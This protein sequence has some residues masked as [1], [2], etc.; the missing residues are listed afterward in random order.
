MKKIKKLKITESHTL[1]L[2]H[3]QDHSVSKG[4]KRRFMAIKDSIYRLAKEK[5]ILFGKKLTVCDIGCNA[6]S[7]SCL[8]LADGHQIFGIDLD[9]QLLKLAK[10]SFEETNICMGSAMCLPWKSNSFDVCLVPELLEHVNEWEKCLDEFARIL[11]PAGLL[12]ISTVNTLCPKQQE[13]NLPFYSWYPKRLKK[14]CEKLA[15]GPRPDLANYATFPAVSWFSF[16]SLRKELKNRGFCSYGRF[17]IVDTSNK[18]ELFKIILSVLRKD[19]FMKL[20][21]NILTPYTVIL[22]IKKKK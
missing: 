1:F 17:D 2:E 4:T 14:Y 6:G 20:I 18:S 22:G 10:K 9:W 12:Y 16:Y 15:T 13:F 19:S 21:G 11:K 8:W 3:Y 5:N 7:Q